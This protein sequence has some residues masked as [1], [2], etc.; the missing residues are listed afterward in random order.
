MAYQ[1]K[2]YMRP[3]A[4]AKENMLDRSRRGTFEYT[5]HEVVAG[6]FDKLTS[7]DKDAW[8][9]AFSEVA[10]P[11]EQRAEEAE[12]KGEKKAAEDNYLKAYGYYRLGRYPATNSPGKKAA[13]QR[14]V[15]CYLKAAR[16]FDPPLE[17]VDIPL[18]GGSAK[19]IGYYRRPKTAGRVPLLVAWGGIDGYKE[20]RRAGPF[21][22]RGIAVLALDNAGVGQAPVKALQDGDRYFDSILEYAAARDDVDRSRIAIMGSSTGGYWAAKLAHTRHEL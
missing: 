19:I 17:K 2:R 15:D 3:Y 12:A 21:L 14:S 11:Y 9:A 7:L 13:Y 22:E 18:K 4:E 8:A 20:D 5:D 10:K 16:Y 1:I 6:V